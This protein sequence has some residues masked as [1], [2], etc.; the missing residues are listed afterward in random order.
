MVTSQRATIENPTGEPPESEK[1]LGDVTRNIE[2]WLTREEASRFLGIAVTT[3]IAYEK[4]S[5]LHPVQEPRPDTK[6]RVHMVWFHDPQELVALRTKLQD[7]SKTDAVDTSTWLT[8]NEACDSL[9]ISTQ[10]L[11]NYEQR[12]KLHPLKAPRRDSRGHEQMV[13]VYDPK[14][15]QKL[16]R[17]LGRTFNLREPGELEAQ[18][19]QMI[20]E[21]K[22]NR[23]IVIALRLTSDRVRELRE[24]WQNDGGADLM[25]TTEAKEALEK[26]VGAFKD[27]TDLVAL[28]TAK[29]S[30]PQNNN[31]PR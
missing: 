15:L 17:G 9:S 4:R 19:F 23:E 10:T 2:G 24:R 14:E 28:V 3:V 27:V 25:I 21:G 29:L 22:D 13:V 5:L 30:E 11:K 20:E 8:R 12:N 1:N 31:A 26:L 16:P 18:C 7:R 6:G